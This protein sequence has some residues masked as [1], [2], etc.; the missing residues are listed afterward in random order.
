[1]AAVV[2]HSPRML[3]TGELVC[4]S[5]FHE[6]PCSKAEVLPATEHDVLCPVSADDLSASFCGWCR[7]ARLVRLHERMAVMQESG[8]AVARI[9]LKSAINDSDALALI[10]RDGWRTGKESGNA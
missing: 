9:D 2:T 1:M 8:Q 10:W 4:A 6:W 5:C 7:I 3:S